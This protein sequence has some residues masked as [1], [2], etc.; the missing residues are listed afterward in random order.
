MGGRATTI[1]RACPT[2]QPRQKADVARLCHCRDAIQRAGHPP[3]LMG[4]GSLLTLR[5]RPAVPGWAARDTIRNAARRGDRA[6][7]PTS[8]QWSRVGMHSWW[9]WRR[10]WLLHRC[11]S[12]THRCTSQGSSGYSMFLN[13]PLPSG[14]AE[15]KGPDSR[16][17][18]FFHKTHRTVRTMRCQSCR[19][20]TAYFVTKMSSSFWPSW[21]TPY[22]PTTTIDL[23]DTVQCVP[24]ETAGD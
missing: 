9:C 15:V 5:R 4:P 6:P 12:Q 3:C 1:P 24:G 7:S 23:H 13:A 16:G 11:P 18:W 21:L 14:R 2:F 17:G 20:S 8:Q 22:V 19:P 10:W